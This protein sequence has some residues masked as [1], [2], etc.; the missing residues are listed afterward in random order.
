MN[1]VV[2]GGQQLYIGSDSAVSYT[3]PHSADIGNGTAQGWI[4]TAGTN[5]SVGTLTFPDYGFI[6][7][8]STDG[9]GIYK[10]FATI[11]GTGTG[12][13]T[14]IALAT[15]PYPSGASAWEYN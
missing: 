4:Y 5:S 2:P 11:G 3:E 15:V 1:V 8:A 12:N 6:A 14:G 7:C 13:C 10:I 9:P